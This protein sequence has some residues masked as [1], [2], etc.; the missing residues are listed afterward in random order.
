MTRLVTTPAPHWI[1]GTGAS[2]PGS[3]I[4]WTSLSVSSFSVLMTAERV[5]RG[6]APPV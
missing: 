5:L 4:V 2:T 3:L 6:T 1:V